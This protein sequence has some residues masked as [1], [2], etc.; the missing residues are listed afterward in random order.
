MLGEKLS[1]SWDKITGV[2][3]FVARIPLMA[4][5][6]AISA[7]AAWLL[8]VFAWRLAVAIYDRF[9]SRPFDWG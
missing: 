6:V 8:L 4:L 2:I 3:K 5:A 9:L 1:D 7:I